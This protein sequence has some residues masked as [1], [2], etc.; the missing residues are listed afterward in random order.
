MN[1]DFCLYFSSTRPLDRSTSDSECPQHEKDSYHHCCLL[2]RMWSR[3]CDGFHLLGP[4]HDFVELG[5]WG[6]V[7]QIKR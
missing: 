5:P 2:Q 6:A 1:I 3:L 7:F 4:A